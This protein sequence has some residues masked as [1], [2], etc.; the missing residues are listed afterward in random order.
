MTFRGKPTEI[1]FRFLR[2][3]WANWSFSAFSFSAENDISFSSAFS[4]TAKN[5]KRI[6]GRPNFLRLFPSCKKFAVILRIF[7]F[8]TGVGG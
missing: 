6:F 2:G 3:K 7:V 8:L 4:F 5:E 1:H